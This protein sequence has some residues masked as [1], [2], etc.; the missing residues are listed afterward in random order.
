MKKI[1][2]FSLLLFIHNAFA[3]VVKGEVIIG[4]RGCSK[5]DY[6]I[7]ATNLGFVY[8][9]QYS[10]NFDKGDEVVGELNSYGF[11]DVLINKSSG[12]LYIDDYMMSKTKAAEK[13]FRN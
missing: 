7:I 3:D 8:A 12:R 2:T 5:R 13:C 9:Q 1:L 11:K 6:I 10:G 4:E